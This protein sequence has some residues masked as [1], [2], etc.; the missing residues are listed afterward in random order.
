MSR[1]SPEGVGSASQAEGEQCKGN[2]REMGCPS[3]N[4][5]SL[6]LA[7]HC[8]PPG[9]TE[10]SP[11][12]PFFFSVSGITIVRTLVLKGKCTFLFL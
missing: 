8:Q 7:L 10:A 6:S 1:G 2:S 9:P 4:E 11:V 12:V 5:P 3:V